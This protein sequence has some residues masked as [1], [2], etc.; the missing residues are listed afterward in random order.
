M[1]RTKPI[2]F[3]DIVVPK[4]P[5]TNNV[6]VNVITIVT[7]YSQQ[8]KHVFKEKEPVKTKGAKD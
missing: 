4:S 6:L 8:S 1:F 3:N 7:T 2:S 5:K